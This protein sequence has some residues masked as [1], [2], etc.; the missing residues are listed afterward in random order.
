MRSAK[1]N[2]FLPSYPYRTDKNLNYELL[3]K[4][5]L[6]QLKLGAVQDEKEKVKDLFKEQEYI[7]RFISSYTPY[8]GILL[9][10][11]TGTGKSCAFFG[12]VESLRVK[13][14]YVVFDKA[15]VLAPTPII[16][17]NL[18]RNL[19]QSCSKRYKNQTQLAIDPFYSFI[20]ISLSINTFI[21][22]FKKATKN[23][24]PIII[25]DEVHRFIG[26]D[27]F[28]VLMELLYNIP[29]KKIII[30]SATPMVDSY[31]QIFKVMALLTPFPT[32]PTKEI[33]TSFEQKYNKR[34]IKKDGFIVTIK[35]SLQELFKGRVSYLKKSI[36]T[37]VNV[38]TNSNFKTVLKWVP[39]PN[40]EWGFK[41]T[42]NQLTLFLNELYLEDMQS[43]QNS[44]Y[45]K[46]MIPIYE[47]KSV[48]DLSK[49]KLPIEASLF[50]FPKLIKYSDVLKKLPI[51]Y[52]IEEEEEDEEDADGDVYITSS[53]KGE[54]DVMTPEDINKQFPTK[55]DEQLTFYSVDKKQGDVKDGWKHYLQF[56]EKTNT[57]SFKEVITGY[58]G[59]LSG[60]E[61]RPYKERVLKKLL[62]GKTRQETVTNIKSYS[63]VYY[64]ILK[65][66]LD[67]PKEKHFVYIS[68][69]KGTGAILF[70]MLLNLLNYK[71]YKNANRSPNKRPQYIL[72]NSLVSDTKT[73]KKLIDRC[74][75]KLNA[76]GDYIQVI[77]GGKAIAT[78][79]DLK[80]IR[81]IHIAT[82]DWNYTNTK[83]ATGRGI[84]SGSHDDLLPNERTVSI[85]KY[86]P[87]PQGVTTLN[88]IV[89]GRMYLRSFYKDLNIKQIEY[90]MKI[91]AVNC[92][93]FYKR[94]YIDGS[95]YS[96]LCDYKPCAYKC[97]DIPPNFL[98]A[99]LHEYILPPTEIDKSNQLLFLTSDN[100]FIPFIRKCFTRA[101]SLHFSEIK[102]FIER[103]LQ[104]EIDG[105]TLLYTLY[106]IIIRQV[107]FIS[108]YSSV[109]YL[110]ENHNHFYLDQSVNR[111]EL[112]NSYYQQQICFNKPLSIISNITTKT[113]LDTVNY[114]QS[115]GNNALRRESMYKIP[116]SIRMKMLKLLLI[117]PPG[118]DTQTINW[119]LNYFQFD[120]F[121]VD[122]VYYIRNVKSPK[123]LEVSEDPCKTPD[124]IQY[125]IYY[126]YYN[127]ETKQF[128]LCDEKH[129]T[130]IDSYIR[131]SQ[132]ILIEK[133][134]KIGFYGIFQ[135][136]IMSKDRF[137]LLD[138]KTVDSKADARLIK[139]G[140]SCWNYNQEKVSKI[141]TKL[142][143]KDSKSKTTN[144]EVLFNYLSRNGVMSDETYIYNK[145]K[146]MYEFVYREN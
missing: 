70:A 29:S 80:H 37:S 135:K 5:E 35:D 96:Q 7:A 28:Y 87:C 79:I 51:Y 85:Y 127:Q 42:P 53:I 131:T 73:N 92:P 76:Y 75:N 137:K 82:P 60:E 110:N 40:S 2:N 83:Q 15:V 138:I 36:T 41:F 100:Q 47:N 49:N 74:N 78:G 98:D 112:T 64:R 94:N 39:E 99:K 101:F 52:M 109:Q 21:L 143:L 72:L 55:K 6:Y 13:Q 43:V 111:N 116:H 89:F 124:K 122:G 54:Y 108:A 67:H 107:P 12:A 63:I 104:R 34:I 77:I 31:T 25:I 66:I 57:F 144:C 86:V 120:Y 102:L 1:I 132:S 10:H 114:I 33:I 9:V 20:P 30:G 58:S 11:A 141:L 91:N 123:M 128:E 81:H 146:G 4:K 71:Y 118:Q 139:S 8:D 145:N 88:Y 56:D 18:K 93:V 97:N 113:V 134:K 126:E 45:T 46:K 125:S 103:Q 68:I 90:F 26:S 129:Q 59:R 136:N 50:V 105:Q 62:L 16:L 38:Q 61:L 84:R 24:T 19:V 130:R 3:K 117:Y 22:Q 119:L 14:R 142:K 44:F 27:M 115:I 95:D 69:V 23:K 106:E 17:N 32:R 121:K 48:L 133:A 65:S 140:R